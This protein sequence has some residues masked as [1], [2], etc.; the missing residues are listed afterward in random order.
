MVQM[1]LL[2]NIYI[3]YSGISLVKYILPTTERISAVVMVSKS[4][5]SL[6]TSHL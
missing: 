3:I 2:E 1:V 5:N 6:L 4:G